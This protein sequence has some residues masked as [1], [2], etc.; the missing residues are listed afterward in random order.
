[1]EF[2]GIHQH[3]V[4]FLPTNRLSVPKNKALGFVISKS[5]NRQ[6]LSCGVCSNDLIAFTF[7]NLH[8]RNAVKRINIDPFLGTHAISL[9]I[10]FRNV[11]Q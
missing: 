1:M 11:A 8:I 2:L 10:L 6:S 7:Q 3:V 9:S 5:S 4:K